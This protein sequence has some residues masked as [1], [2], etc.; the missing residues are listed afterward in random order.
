M[1]VLS[2]KVFITSPERM[3]FSVDTGYTKCNIEISAESNIH[4]VVEIYRVLTQAAGFAEQTFDDGIVEYL[5]QKGYTITS[6]TET[7]E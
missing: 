4:E 3:T 6:N 2:N 5:T 1:T 7:T